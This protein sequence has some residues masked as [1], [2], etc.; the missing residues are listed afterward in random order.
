L[1]TIKHFPAKLKKLNIL[2]SFNGTAANSPNKATATRV[3]ITVA[4][5]LMSENEYISYMRDEF[6]SNLLTA[7]QGAGDDKMLQMV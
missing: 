3:K 4:T 2:L 6:E 5:N 7:Q 1:S